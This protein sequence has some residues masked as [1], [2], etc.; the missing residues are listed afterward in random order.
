[1]ANAAKIEKIIC[2]SNQ[3]SMLML[4]TSLP[5]A[6]DLAMVLPGQTFHDGEDS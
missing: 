2:N 3:K 1:M 4:E 6:A 5:T